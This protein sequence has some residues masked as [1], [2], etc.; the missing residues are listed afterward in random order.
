MSRLKKV[1]AQ[2]KAFFSLLGAFSLLL[3]V[4]YGVNVAFSCDQ[5]IQHEKIERQ[6]LVDSLTRSIEQL[7]DL[8]SHMKGDTQVLLSMPGLETFS[9]NAT[10]SQEDFRFFMTY[11]QSRYAIDGVFYYHEPLHVLC[12]FDQQERCIRGEQEVLTHLSLSAEALEAI[13][14]GDGF[15]LTDEEHA[16]RLVIS[17]RLN[18]N[19]VCLRIVPQQLLNQHLQGDTY[20]NPVSLYAN[21]KLILVDSA[22]Q[23]L[24]TG[25]GFAYQHAYAY[26]IAA[27][28]LQFTLYIANMTAYIVWKYIKQML[29]CYGSILLVV[30]GLLIWLLT[31]RVYKPIQN[32]MGMLPKQPDDGKSE[33]DLIQ[34]AIRTLQKESLTQKDQLCAQKNLLNSQYALLR[35][36][37]LQR[38]FSG[39]F[40]DYN[41]ILLLEKRYCLESCFERYAALIIWAEGIDFETLDC[42]SLSVPNAFELFF[43]DNLA[44]AVLLMISLSPQTDLGTAVAQISDRFIAKT[45]TKPCICCSAIHK[46]TAEADTAWLEASLV[47]EKTMT[48]SRQSG[49][50][51]YSSQALKG[52]PGQNAGWL[53]PMEQ[54]LMQLTL[55][56]RTDKFPTLLSQYCERI[57]LFSLRMQKVL[58]VSLFTRIISLNAAENATVIREPELL[59]LLSSHLSA[60]ELKSHALGLGLRVFPQCA[61]SAVSYSKRFETVLK[62]VLQHIREETLCAAGVAEHFNMSQSSLTREF[63]KNTGFG[64]ASYIHI[65]R[66]NMAKA[67]LSETDDTIKDIATK[68]GYSNSLALTRAFHKYEGTTPGNYR[69]DQ[70]K[71]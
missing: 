62:Y 7:S 70:N 32:T 23:S 52:S 24:E 15:A 46:D 66:I 55:S 67:M 38:L 16:T 35:Q 57:S 64:F 44:E 12:G 33:H 39:S 65:Q 37:F 40:I 4:A 56:G 20:D 30:G 31:S 29:L 1:F 53:V 6:F 58:I 45:G 14:S 22:G 71:R 17:N 34:S 8:L 69:A 13:L 60:E 51:F 25:P 68:V 28:E 19:V 63:Q 9:E 3:A 21:W 49:T 54:Q 2:R 48:L 41:E 36:S 50:F 11:A 26:P 61:A 43:V 59:S 5:A 47:N 27:Q 18:D 42:Q 10:V